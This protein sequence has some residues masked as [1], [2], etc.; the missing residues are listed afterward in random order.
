VRRERQP[1]AD[2][3]AER[4]VRLIVFLC[5]AAFWSSACRRPPAGVLTLAPTGMHTTGACTAAADGTL[6]MAPGASAD[7]TIYVDAGAVTVTVTAAPSS[8]DDHPQME[9]WLAGEKIGAVTPES[10]EDRA[11]RFSAQARTSGPTALRLAYVTEAGQ[12]DRPAPAL[13]VKK[14]VITQP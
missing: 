9:L 4:G 6:A 14:V 3:R 11:V 8:V 7:S 10:T 12:S 1:A 5:V 13:H 2:R